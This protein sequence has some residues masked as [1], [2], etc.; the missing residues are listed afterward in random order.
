MREPVRVTRCR[1]C[2]SERLEPVL[3]LGDQALTGVFPASA[4]T[5]VPSGPLALL[6]CHGDGGCGLVQL[7]HDYDLDELYGDHYGYRSGLNRSMIR[8]L[9]AKV[10]WLLERRP[11]ERGDLVLDIGAND[12]TTLSRYPDSVD[13]IGI[14]PTIAKFAEH[15]PPGIERV[16]DF[17][18]AGVFRRHAGARRARIVTSIAMFYDLPAPMR[19]VEDVASILADDG[20]WHL[21]QSYLPLML[22]RTSYDTVCHE[23]LEYYALGQ[24]AWMA[25]RAGLR[26]T[27]V[28]L[29]EVNGG[30]FACT[31]ESGRGHAP[32]VEE[33]LRGEAWLGSLEPWRDFA[34]RVDRHAEALPALLRRLRSEGASVYGLGA[35]TK[36]NVVL[37]RC[38]IDASLLTAI[39]E[40]NPDKYGCV[41][42]GTRIPIVPEED[43]RARDPDVL[44]VLPWHFRAGFEERERPFVERGG[45][46]LFPLPE[47]DLV[48][49]A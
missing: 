19:F 37:Q 16:A 26:I 8:H 5:A 47:I 30:S 28:E 9:H 22:E 34:A 29:N 48:G 36:G 3:D 24:I 11:L 33:M 2:G 13:R 14:D 43:V 46:L 27:E 42:P 41:T 17:F 45:R 25:D 35:S 38:G 21:E 32:A 31:L 15:Y 6:K 4:D 1:I 18:D 10:D 39:A 23:H 44:M 49:A 40:I 20:V 12:G 7:A